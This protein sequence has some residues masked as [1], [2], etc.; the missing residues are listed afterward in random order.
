MYGVV[1]SRV[2]GEIAG[3]PR[4]RVV[5]TQHHETCQDHADGSIDDVEVRDDKGVAILQR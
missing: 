4:V 5:D 3:E 1:Y 2:D